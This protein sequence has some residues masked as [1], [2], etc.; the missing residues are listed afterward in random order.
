[1]TG[2]Y[3]AWCLATLWLAATP[4]K[5]VDKVADEAAREQ[6]AA[7][8]AEADELIASAGAPDLFVNETK[9]GAILIRHR[10]SN[11]QCLFNPGSDNELLLLP[12]APARGEHIACDGPT[13]LFHMSYSIAKAGEKDTLDTAFGEAVSTIKTRWPAAMSIKVKRDSNQEVLEKIAQQAPPSRT[14]WFLV[15]TEASWVFSR[16]SVAKVGDWLITMRAS[17]PVDSQEPAESLTEMLWLTRLMVMVDPKLGGKP[18]ATA[19]A[20]Q[21]A[22]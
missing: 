2:F 21:K 12:D 15:K 1:M 4:V 14:S 3:L 18:V 20:G 22:P 11:F 10:L 19:E 9:D 7:V 17:G 13:M 8:R 6:S 16:V 5:P